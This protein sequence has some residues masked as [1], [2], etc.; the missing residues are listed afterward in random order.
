MYV[1]NLTLAP[2]ALGIGMSWGGGALANDDIKEIPRKLNN[3]NIEL[4]EVNVVSTSLDK[5]VYTK[6]DIDSAPTGNNDLTSL[7]ADMP[8]IRVDQSVS[9]GGNRA[10]LAP[11]SFS[12]YGESPFQ[13]QF[14]I[15]GIEVN[16]VISPQSRDS[17]T[18]SVGTVTS[19]SQAYNIDTD[20]L[21]EVVVYDSNV[22]V[23][24]GS[25]QG[26]VIDAKIKKPT[27]SNTWKLKQNFNSS[28]LT[29][30]KIATG[31][32]TSWA[33]G[34]PGYSSIWRKTFRTIQGDIA[35]PYGAAALLSYSRR[36][37]LI[38]R[39]SDQL[40]PPSSGIATSNDYEHVV[41]QSK[42]VVD[43]G[44][45]KLTKDFGSGLD[46]DVLLKY[47]NRKEDGLS[48]PSTGTSYFRSANWGNEQDSRGASVD[49]TKILG[50]GIL[51]FNNSFD[52]LNSIR[53]S[54]INSLDVHLFRRTAATFDNDKRYTTGGWGNEQL[55]QNQFISKL[56]LDLDTLNLAGMSH[57]VYAGI[58]YKNIDAHFY[59]PENIYTNSYTHNLNGTT[60]HAQQNVYLAGDVKV[61]YKNVGLYF[62]DS[63]NWKSLNLQLGLR[64]DRDNFLKNNNV[65][66]RAKFS[67]DIG[68]TANHRASVG[69]S[70]YFG[71]DMLGFAMQHEKN[72]LVYR[73][74]TNDQADVRQISVQD[75]TFA[76]LKTPH[77]DELFSG[78]EFD[79]GNQFQTG[80][81]YVERKSRNGISK[82]T[83]AT[84]KYEYVNKS[85]SN[86]KNFIFSFK[87]LK[88][89]SFA[90]AKWFGGVDFSWQ[91]TKRNHDALL[92]WESEEYDPAEKILV[93][94]VVTDYQNKPTSEFN[95]PRK[96]SFKWQANWSGSG[97][98]WSNR[99]NWNS[100]R[101]GI[102]YVGTRKIGTVS[103][104]NYES[105]TLPSNWTWDASLIWKP[106]FAKGLLL[107]LE[108]LNILN[109]VEEVAIGSPSAANNIRYQNGREIW[110]NVGY[111]F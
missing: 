111:E 71:A 62:S 110:L 43:N 47:A 55:K 105:K 8:S 26:A 76:G 22:P 63:I 29:E 101:D 51:K 75:H 109:K 41:G 57:D 66:P 10:S 87:T 59:R 20:L 27:G 84:G 92:G 91:K 2:I 93:N 96:V 13:N 11:E 83:I 30:Q 67:W 85:H 86:S 37:S 69:W 36:E 90:S 42:D 53:N 34:A 24:F 40:K 7:I 61:N 77:S 79:I 45:V 102:A 16:N 49:L 39:E 94:G 95:L 23:E 78:Y 89:A 97:V 100:K 58:D 82:N 9:G 38:T 88:P 4:P 103:Y 12:V 98:L 68:G 19:F 80:I 32:E 17:T 64:Y 28:N 104:D 21:G 14:Q 74:I 70:R 72:R 18:A 65:A 33:Q 106:V 60:L 25:F 107:N 15:D 73:L 46:V 31:A 56:R 50:F 81:S 99:L 3:S 48:R 52:Y 6:D 44:F 5:V 54:D 108:V 1:K 35:L